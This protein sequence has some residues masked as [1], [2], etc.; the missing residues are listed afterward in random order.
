M[1][2]KA[3]LLIEVQVGQTKQVVEAIH[4]LGGG[5]ASVDTVAG[6]Y[7]IIA[8]IQGETLD[9]IGELITAKVGAVAGITRTVTCLAL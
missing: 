9:D 8:V 4:K 5:V 1:T 7:D 3:Y 6:P 2:V